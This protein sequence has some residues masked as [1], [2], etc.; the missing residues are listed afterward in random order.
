MDQLLHLLSIPL[1]LIWALPYL[2]MALFFVK[3]VKKWQI[4]PL[5]K[6][7]PG[8]NMIMTEKGSIIGLFISYYV[9]SSFSIFTFYF[10]YN[11]I[12]SLAV[13]GKTY[14]EY[15]NGDFKLDYDPTSDILTYLAVIA[16]LTVLQFFLALVWAVDHEKNLIMLTD[17]R[18]VALGARCSTLVG[19]KT[20]NGSRSSLDIPLD[21]VDSAIVNLN[22]LSTI[23][24]TG[25][26]ILNSSAQTFTLHEFEM[27]E[28]FKNTVM[29][30]VDFKKKEAAQLQMQQQ[31]KL[32]EAQRVES[33]QLAEQ[34]RQDALY[35][36]H[37]QAQAMAKAMLEAQG[38]A[39]PPQGQ[40]IPMQ[41]PHYPMPEQQFSVQMPQEQQTSGQ[42]PQ[43]IPQGDPSQYQGQAPRIAYCHACATQ[44]KQGAKFCSA[45]GTPQ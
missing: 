36:A 6:L 14:F 17:K 7:L 20:V 40:D 10:I 3:R 27:P 22:F 26:I 31:A 15:P 11:Q 34:Q 28:R 33:E 24:K 13:V 32:A 39:V 41:M 19:G 38:I 16:A 25:T 45:C 5:D 29:L 9:V 18:I 42:M 30:Q 43:Q 37:F 4:R 35:L 12:V 1:S 8:E 21:K 44:L 23:T 2:P